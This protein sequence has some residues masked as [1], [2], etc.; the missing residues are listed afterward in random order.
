MCSSATSGIA[1]LVDML[2]DEQCRVAGQHMDSCMGSFTAMLLMRQTGGTY[3][4]PAVVI[5][6]YCGAEKVTA[7]AGINRQAGWSE[8]RAAAG[9]GAA[10]LQAGGRQRSRAQP[11]RPAAGLSAA[12]AGAAAAGKLAA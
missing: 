4:R 9:R 2:S 10:R 7:A 3:E 5:C 1:R 12:G 11:E 6:A 8:P